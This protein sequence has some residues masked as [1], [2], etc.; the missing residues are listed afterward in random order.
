LDIEKRKWKIIFAETGSNEV[1]DCVA[2]PA[3]VRVTS[4]EKDAGF[5]KYEH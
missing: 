4:D 1:L 2:V 3:R 5:E